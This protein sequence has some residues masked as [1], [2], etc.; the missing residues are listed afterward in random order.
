MTYRPDRGDVLDVPPCWK[1]DHVYETRDGAII[2]RKELVVTAFR[3]GGR[4]YINRELDIRWAAWRRGTRRSSRIITFGS[5][6]SARRKF[7][8]LRKV[9]GRG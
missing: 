1:P 8:S 6:S 4:A 9:G 7:G 5:W 2:V 3:D